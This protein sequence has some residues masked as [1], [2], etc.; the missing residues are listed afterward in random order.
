MNTLF[1]YVG[2]ENGCIYKC[3]NGGKPVKKPQHK[4]TA[5]GC[6][7]FGVKLDLTHVPAIE[8][9]CNEHDVCYDTCNRPKDTCD[10]DF[11]DCLTRTCKDFKKHVSRKFYEGCQSTADLMYAATMALGCKPYKDSQRDACLCPKPRIEL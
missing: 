2:D 3:S 10:V 4:P 9:C 7:S 1:D 11:K 6:G 8:R 5:N